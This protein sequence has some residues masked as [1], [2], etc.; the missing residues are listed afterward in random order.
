MLN[1]VHRDG[2]KLVQFRRGRAGCR[3]DFFFFIPTTPAAGGADASTSSQVVFS[4]YYYERRTHADLSLFVHDAGRPGVRSDP[5][6][7][8]HSRDDQTAPRLPMKCHHGDDDGRII[9]AV[10]SSAP[11]L[12]RTG[13]DR[14]VGRAQLQ[15]KVIWSLTLLSCRPFVHVWNHRALRDPAHPRLSFCHYHH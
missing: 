1:R 5:I 15:I 2:S 7:P 12:F 8:A 6:T 13:L 4:E 3:E 14:I 11:E 9:S 10:F